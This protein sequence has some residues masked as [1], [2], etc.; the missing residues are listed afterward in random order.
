MGLRTIALAI[1]L[2]VSWVKMDL[3]GSLVI[4]AT[5]GSIDCVPVSM[6]PSTWMTLI[7][8][9]VCANAH[10]CLCERYIKK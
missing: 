9:V 4:T 6:K 10:R 3:V 5:Y 8:F 7:T 1:A 2:N